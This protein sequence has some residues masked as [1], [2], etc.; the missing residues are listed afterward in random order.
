MIKLYGTHPTRAS[1]VMWMLSELDLDY[2][3]KSEDAPELADLNPNEKVP[4]LVDGSLVVWESMAINLFLAERYGGP[5]VPTSEAGRIAV[6]QWSFWAATEIEERAAQTA[7]HRFAFPEAERDPEVAT[8]AEDA[9]LTALE[10]LERTLAECQY[11]LGGDFTVADLNIASMLFPALPGGVDLSSR[12]RV[13]DWLS[14][15]LERPACPFR[16]ILRDSGLAASPPS[17]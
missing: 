10:A 5:L 16:R 12:P 1:R 6:L 15:C 8:A 7:R 14:R 11:V 4:V 17:D 3:S 13:S 2:E 9:L